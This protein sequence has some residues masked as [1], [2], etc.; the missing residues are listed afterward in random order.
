MADAQKEL[1]IVFTSDTSQAET[2][3][4]KFGGVLSNVGQIAAGIGLERLAS[5]VV[6]F[7]KE[8]I[9]TSI[10][11]YAE[12]ENLNAQL[13]AVLKSTHDA[14]GMSREALIDLSKSIQSTT[15]Y[16]DEAALSVE[17]M[18]L[19]FTNIGKETFP[20]A[21]SAVLDMSTA[22]GENS[23]DA[24]IQLGKALQDPVLGITALRRVGVAFTD[25]QKKV[26]KGLVDTGHTMD[27]Q[28]MILK[29][30]N[31]EFGGSAA[32]AADTYAGHVKSLKNAIDDVQEVIGKHITEGLNPYIQGATTAA[33]QV[34]AFM[35]GQQSLTTTIK[36][37]V[38]WVG[39][40]IDLW[41]K[42]KDTIMGFI[43]QLL[44]SFQDFWNALVTATSTAISIIG[45]I[46]GIFWQNIQSMWQVYGD[47][48]V[49][50][51][52]G[53]WE[54]LSNVFKLGLDVLTGLLKIFSDVFTGN[55]SKLWSD[56][57]TTFSKIID[58]TKGIF[59]GFADWAMG[60]INGIIDGIKN[61]AGMANSKG[62]TPGKALGGYASGLTL[63]GENGPELVNLPTG[64]YVNNNTQT[65]KMMGGATINI[66]NPTVRSDSDITAIV[67]QVKS[68]LGR[69]NELARLGAI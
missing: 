1:K 28:K 41:N 62:N 5:D 11:A 68:A 10:N 39:S 50:I 18:L 4:S 69:Q 19:T 38:P 12:S 21:T 47:S 7:G 15:T 44:P 3:I 53:T 20:E 37:I 67:N 66:N 30:I 33:R 61:A 57:K 59:K 49:Q 35:E 13:N 63:V 16:S 17:N 27:A 52:K 45:T 60:I 9:T 36:N 58:D 48:I 51:L 22:L 55:W 29:E 24:A 65:N 26:I 42:H 54:V 32:A 64:S 8:L 31:T 23:K 6:N 43:N 46:I 25:D 56:L 34:Q 2:G 40:L 14:S